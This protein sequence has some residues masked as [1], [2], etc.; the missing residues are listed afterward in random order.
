MGSFMT[1]D[2]FE[3]WNH[4]LFLGLTM[5]FWFVFPINWLC[6]R[7]LYRN[8]LSRKNFFF[9]QRPKKQKKTKKKKTFVIEPYINKKKSWLCIFPIPQKKKKWLFLLTVSFYVTIKAAWKMNQG[10][11]FGLMGYSFSQK[12]K[13]NMST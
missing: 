5:V 12:R 1:P 2:V 4:T 8:T 7:Y 9:N 3:T 11:R 13:R 10:K 6:L